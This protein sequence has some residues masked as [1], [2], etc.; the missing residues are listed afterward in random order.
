MRHYR[1]TNQERAGSGF[2]DQFVIEGKELVGAVQTLSFPLITLTGAVVD[3]FV[4]IRVD[5]GI[6]GTAGATLKAEVGHDKLNGAG[7]VDPNHWVDATTVKAATGINGTLIGPVGGSGATNLPV[8]VSSSTVVDCTI[9]TAGSGVANFDTTTNTG[10]ISIFM[11]IVQ[12]DDLG[13]DQS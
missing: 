12:S 6:A 7:S 5:E 8:V 3:P 1:L 10:Q 11:R 2:T 4:V 9:T 13:Y